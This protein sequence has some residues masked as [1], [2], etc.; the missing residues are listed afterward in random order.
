[1]TVFVEENEDTDLGD[2][3]SLD[4]IFSTQFTIKHFDST[5]IEG[6][7]RTHDHRPS[8]L[9]RPIVMQHSLRRLLCFHYVSLS[10]PLSCANMDSSAGRASPLHMLLRWHQ[11]T[12]SSLYRSL[13]SVF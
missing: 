12:T 3:V 11:M 10:V 5:W 4:E 6:N 8:Q 13:I 9:C 2:P 7:K 1:M